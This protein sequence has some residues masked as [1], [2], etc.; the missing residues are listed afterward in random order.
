MNYDEKQEEIIDEWVERAQKEFSYCETCQPYE[1]KEGGAIWV[2]GHP[3]Y[4]SFILE[5]IEVPE[6]LRNEVVSRLRCPNCGNQLSIADEVGVLSDYEI[7]VNDRV[8]RLTLEIEPDIEGFYQ[9]LVKFPYLGARHP[10]AEQII[11]E[12]KSIKPI[13]VT[14]E[15]WYRARTISTSDKFTTNDMLPPDP[16]KH[17]ISEGR[18]NHYGQSH[19]YL[20]SEPQGC[21][22]EICKTTEKVVWIQKLIIQKL[23]AV[24]DLTENC[25]EEWTERMDKT[26]YLYGG[27]LSNRRLIETVDPNSS[28]KPEYFI[29]RFIADICKEFGINGLI[30]PSAV[31][32][33]KNLVIFNMTELVYSFDGE[34]E[35][36]V[37][38]KEEVR[39]F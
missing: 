5:D 35:I 18:F 13:C 30:F 38:T 11:R 31:Y 19:Y 9:H 4:L 26:P 36:L 24:I 32:S 33:M 15:T 37:G 20:G 2:L 16:S 3:N 27:I 6:E 22:K 28:W 7:K 39:L 17:T 10:I 23:D 8:E 14:N 12:I 21:I 25:F 1:S 34:P 29:P